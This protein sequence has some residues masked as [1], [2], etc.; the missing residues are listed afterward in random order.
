MVE[1]GDIYYIKEGRISPDH[2]RIPVIICDKIGE[3]YR[4]RFVMP[5]QLV[6]D[7]YVLTEHDIAYYLE[8]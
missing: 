4:G 3:S 7:Y 2:K 6:H 5:G 1:I 8:R